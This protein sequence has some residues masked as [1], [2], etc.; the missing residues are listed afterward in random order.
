MRAALAIGF[1]IVVGAAFAGELP[2]PLTDADFRSYETARVKLGQLLFYDRVLSGSYRV[3]CATCHNHDRA[4]SNG[5][6]L[7]GTQAP[8]GDELAINGLPLYDA[9]KPSSRHAPTLFNLGAKQFQT[10]FSDG[11]VGVNAKGDFVS[12]AGEALPEGLTDVLAVQA[13]FPAVAGDELVGR[14]DSDVKAAAHLGSAA[15]WDALAK[16]VQDLPDYWP[17]FQRA[18]PEMKTKA[19]ISITS[20]VNAI[21]AFVGS[22]W[23]SVNSPF[24]R[25]LKGE[26]GALGDSAKRGMVL[27]YGKAGCSACHSGALQTDH[28]F[29]FVPTGFWR[30]D[31]PVED[32]N[33]KIGLGRFAV[34]GNA[35]DR[36]AMRTPSLRNV[37][38]T[39]PYGSAGSVETIR[40]IVLLHLDRK[41]AVE[42]LVQDVRA[43]SHVDVEARKRLVRQI[44]EASARPVSGVP[45]RPLDD[46]QLNDLLAF[47]G[48][49]TD[50]QSLKGLFGKPLDVPSSLALD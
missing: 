2:A 30:F 25:F 14:V 21:S 31:Q 44:R 9:L 45:M 46:E 40:E 28:K 18:Y 43:L 33:L 50:E 23:R 1:S 5:V 16:R 49:L 29:H 47:L 4:S 20:I 8:K 11:R 36:F 42:K 15:I 12:P 24:D 38:Q 41:A 26:R 34:T 39:A 37:A 3:S 7:K 17:H 10:L 22:E 19:D 32:R 48:A 27:F 35:T 6:L 13:L